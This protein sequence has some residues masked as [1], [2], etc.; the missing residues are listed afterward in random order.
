M[1]YVDRF[2]PADSLIA[3]LDSVLVGVTDP[4]IK[5]RYVGFLSVSAVTVYELAVKDIFVSFAKKKHLVFGIFTEELC[6]RLNGRIKR[7]DLD[8]GYI[9]KFGE[10]YSKRFKSKVNEKEELFFDSDGV[11]IKNCYGNIIT[12]RNQFAH[13]GII[14]PTAT[15]DEVKKAYEYGKNVIHCLAESLVR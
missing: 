2:I 9:K 8:D 13:E 14:P 3:H 5:S 4:F 15:Y 6:S 10:K 12:W 7:D 1:P 11:S